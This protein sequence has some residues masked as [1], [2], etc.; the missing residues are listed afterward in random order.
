MYQHQV[1]DFIGM[2]MPLMMMMMGDLAKTYSV[3]RV[4]QLF[5]RTLVRVAYSVDPAWRSPLHSDDDHD[6]PMFRMSRR[7][8]EHALYYRETPL[9]D[10]NLEA[11][12]NSLRLSRVESLPTPSNKLLK[13]STTTTAQPCQD[14]EEGVVVTLEQTKPSPAID[15]NNNKKPPALATS[16]SSSSITTT[17]K[18]SSVNKPPQPA[19]VE[20]PPPIADII[21]LGLPVN[22]T[23]QPAVEQQPPPK[24]D[25]ISLGLQQPEPLS[26]SSLGSAKFTTTTKTSSV[27]NKTPQPAAVEQPPPKTDII[28]LG[29]P[30]NKTPQPAAVEQQ[31]PPK[32]DIISLGLQQSEPLSSSSSLGSAKFGNVLLSNPPE[33]KYSSEI[34]REYYPPTNHSGRGYNKSWNGVL[35]TEDRI[36]LLREEGKTDTHNNKNNKCWKKS[37]VLENSRRGGSLSSSSSSDFDNETPDGGGERGSAYWNDSRF[38]WLDQAIHNNNI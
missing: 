17:T 4:D 6:D 15:D 2:E 31:P 9:D 29:L 1:P 34:L 24:T 14:E 23:P 36:L 38:K 25:I 5:Q 20:E 26:S 33:I 7:L 30:V 13:S 28:S 3:K 10:P 27:V 12:R 22:K 16:S 37:K 18:T 19:A 21:S 8:L 11:I 32:T 35:V